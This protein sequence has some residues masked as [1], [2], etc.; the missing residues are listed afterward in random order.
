MSPQS[1][2]LVAVS[3]IPSMNALRTASD[4]TGVVIR[5]YR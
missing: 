3:H 1:T 4:G 2:S 5:S